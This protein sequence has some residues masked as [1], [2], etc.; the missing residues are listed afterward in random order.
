VP[1]IVQFRTEI[2]RFRMRIVENRTDIVRFRALIVPNRARTCEIEERRPMQFPCSSHTRREQCH[3]RWIHIGI[4]VYEWPAYE[5]RRERPHAGPWKTSQWAAGADAFS[6]RR[7][8]TSPAPSTRNAAVQPDCTAASNIPEPT[9]DSFGSVPVLRLRPVSTHCGPD[10]QLPVQSCR[11]KQ[12]SL[13]AHAYKCRP[14]CRISQF[15]LHKSGQ[16]AWQ[17]AAMIHWLKR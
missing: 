7:T 3:S 6:E 8:R 2:A 9:D 1:R 14:L 13:P 17:R 4:G 10:K 12:L 15:P 11:P 5:R 16:G